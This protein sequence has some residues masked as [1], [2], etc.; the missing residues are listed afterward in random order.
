MCVMFPFGSGFAKE[1]QRIQ[2]EVEKLQKL[3][4]LLSYF[5]FRLNLLRPN[6]KHAYCITD[7]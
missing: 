7:Q 4:G 3:K 1:G 6:T 2:S 5:E